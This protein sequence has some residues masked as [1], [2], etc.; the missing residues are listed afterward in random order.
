MENPAQTESAPGLVSR[1]A[2]LDIL[3]LVRGGANLDEALER[4][5]SF[6][7][8]V[9]PDRGFARA[10]AS[11]VLRRQ[12]TLDAVID[13]FIDK[14]LPKRAARVTDIL[15]LVGAQSALM[16]VADHAS[17]ATAVDLAK[18]FRETEGYAG[19]VNAI[20]RKITRTGKNAAE[21]A[22]ERSDTPGWLWR[23]WERAY[24]PAVAKAIAVAH[25]QEP[26][27]DLTLK[28]PDDAGRLAEALGAEILPTG[29]L[30]LATVSNVTELPG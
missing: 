16:G 11:T 3:T 1:R 27:L 13:P 25:R 2:A 7:E 4:C 5:R 21:K 20:A 30:R 18:S 28:R 24:G 15:R 6:G 23:S 9:G 22:P 26:P 17:V 19:L 8:L 12:G 14:P 10:L 29:G